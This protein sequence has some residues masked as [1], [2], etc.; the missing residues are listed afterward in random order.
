MKS[1]S[2][3]PKPAG[4]RRLLL[5]TP[6]LLCRLRLG[7][8]L[9]DRFV[10]INHRG[11]RTGLPRQTVVEVV[12]SDGAGVVVAAGFGPGS[13]WYRNLLAHP[14]ASMVRGGRTVTVTAVP[15]HP[16]E[17]ARAM[18]E[19]A[20]RH[21]RAARALA[22]FM[23]YRVDGGRADYEAMGRALHFLRLEAPGSSR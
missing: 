11:R 16:D 1:V 22:G 18:A 2:P 8:L 5:R 10:L 3:P 21:R 17:R 19:Y 7:W 6:V 23:G 20:R 13:D 15:L 14:A 12:G 9:G 4:I